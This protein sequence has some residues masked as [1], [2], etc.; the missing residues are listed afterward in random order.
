MY[1]SGFLPEPLSAQDDAK[2][3]DLGIGFTD[4]VPRTTRGMSDLSKKEIMEGKEILIK[5]LEEFK[6]KIAVF[7]SKGIYELYR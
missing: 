7:N 5:K 6:P 3:L 4:I 1:L 2:L